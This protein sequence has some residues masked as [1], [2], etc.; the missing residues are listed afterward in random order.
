M[1]GEGIKRP[2]ISL[3]ILQPPRT[4]NVQ[5]YA[6]S[7][8]LELHSLQS[9]IENRVNND[10][11]SQRNKRRR[12]TA[13][14]NQIARK[15]CRRKRQKVGIMGKAFAKSGL[16][17]DELKKLPRR[18]RRRYELKN[19]P[20][21]GFCT[22]GDGT[23][24]LRTHVWHAK[25][26]AMTKL[27][28]YHLPLCL[29]GRG[30]GSRALLKRLK[31]GVLVHDASYYTALQL[32]GPEDSLISVLRSVLEPS[33]TT[34][35]PDSLISGVTYGSAMLRQDGGLICPPIA[36]VT[37]IWQP[38]SQQN[39]STQL[40]E[41]NHYTSFGQHDI[42]NDSNKHSVELCEKPDKVKHGSPFRHL[43]VWIHA[44]AFEEGFNNLKIACQKE[45]EKTGILIN[46]FSLEGQLAKLELFGLRAF[47]LLQKILHPVGG[48]SEN[49]WQLKKHIVIEEGCV[50]QNRNSTTLKN[51]DSFS[52]C[53]MLPLN[54]KDPRELP[55]KRNVVP[56]EHISTKTLSNA[57]ETKCKELAELGGILEENK[58]L[59]SL[60]WSNPEDCQSNVDDLWYATARG[61]RPP[62]EDSVLSKEK[63][64]ERMVNFCL[65]D[66]D[67]GD[68]STSTKLQSSRSCRILLLKND[69]KELSIGW[70]VILPLSWVKA[71]WIPLISNGAHAIGLQEKHWI[72]CEIG[73]PVFPSDFPDCK[74]YS[75]L[76]EEKEAAFNKKEELRPPSIRH[77][78]VPIQPPWGIVRVTFDKMIS[79]M[80]TPDLSTREDLTNFSSLPNPY[81]GSFKIS[82]SDSWSN[83]FNGT[84]V[85]TGSMLTTFLH[86]TKVGQLLLFPY[87]TDGEA[88]I[89]KFI[90]GELKL[91]PRYTSS[92]ICDHKPSFLR[93]HLRPFKEGCFEEGAVICAPYPSDIFLW[94]SSSEINEEGLQ[95]SQ[96]AM[97][98]Y[99]KEHS[100]GRW[101][102]QI[103]DDSIASKSH[104][105][106]IG[107]VTTGSVQG[108]KSLVAEGFCEAVLLSHLR[109]EQWKE[110][111]MKKR[112]E[113][114]VLVRNLR[115]TAYRLALASI[116]LEYKENDIEFL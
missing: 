45:M 7:R 1:V 68:A 115:S 3:P 98:L 30:K 67:S 11:R 12:T 13:F 49:H 4:I 84:V 83:S 87:A 71:F 101:E 79:S 92:D 113:I 44:S 55:W 86:E 51:G 42:G 74:A 26:F 116:I 112:R 72:T 56:V 106:P 107:F 16:E 99:F 15:G 9:I 82:N 24:R 23:K 57:S 105:W 80:K 20:E 104:R 102:M 69:V 96:S 48:I 91:D 28:G 8:A 103:P 75:C 36:P 111:P 100:S 34:T 2:Q 62:V 6:E 58:D 65:V 10:Y 33:P 25:R 35:H 63:H 60:S 14:N 52:S 40:D 70:S 54:V 43:W 90:N 73:L 108:S 78:R 39:I 94:T 31:E 53:A 85:R 114:Y 50:S 110:M 38:T 97:R 64:H 109:E 21:N 17:E 46:C 81:P 29:Q 61:L 19:N 93:V 18:V 88:R 95:M 89:S 22:S 27:W 77:L 47:Q 32:E 59:C 5:K 76:M 41:Q 66:T 37:Y